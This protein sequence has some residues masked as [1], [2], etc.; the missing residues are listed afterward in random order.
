MTLIISGAAT[1][2]NNRSTSMVDVYLKVEDQQV[3][4]LSIPLSDIQRLSIRPLKWLR[5]VTFAFC[6]AHGDLSPTPDGP[7]VDYNSVALDPSY[8]YVAH[9]DTSLFSDL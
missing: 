5:F 9:G 6:G 1:P 2:N 8:Y 7:P 4:A 3:P